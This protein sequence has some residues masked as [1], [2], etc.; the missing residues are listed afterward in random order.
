MKKS[1]ILLTIIGISFT[2]RFL[3]SNWDSNTKLNPDERFITMV[4]TS[5]KVPS[6]L[7]TYFD[8]H[9][10][11]FNPHNVGHTYYVY[12]TLPVFV[13]KLLALQFNVDTYEK[14]TLFGRHLS[15]VLDTISTLLVFGIAYNLTKRFRTSAIATLVYALAV[16]PIQLSHFY[17]VD[18]WLVLFSTTTLYVLTSKPR[19]RNFAF[20]GLT[21]G[22]AVASKIQAFVLVPLVGVGFLYWLPKMNFKR[23]LLGGVVC[24]IL[25]FVTVRVSQPYLFASGKFLEFRPNPKVLANW[26]ELQR[27]YS[28]ATYANSTD[29]VYFPPASMF[30]KAAPITFLANNLFFWGLGIPASIYLVLGIMATSIAS[31]KNRKLTLLSVIVIW[32][33]GVFLYQSLLFAKYLRYLAVVYPVFAVVAAIGIQWLSTKLNPRVTLLVSCALL[34]PWPMAF[35]SIYLKPHPRVAASEWI[36]THLSANDKVTFEHWDDPL[37]L[38]LPQYPCPLVTQLELP[39]YESDSP[40]KWAKVAAVLNQAD[41]IILSSNRLYGS[42]TWLPERYPITN[43]YYQLLFSGQ[44]GFRLERQF[45]NRPTLPFPVSTCIHLPDVGYGTI[46]KPYENCTT[47][48]LQIVD[49]YTDESFTVYDHPAVFIFK[50]VSPINYFE[51][52]GLQ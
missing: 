43:K 10:S 11:T 3:G 23:W 49:D 24:I 7:S 51:V 8:P 12:G 15:A 45:T 14:V 37:P 32:S 4:T 5:L 6:S 34:V 40:A 28:Q 25:C 42:I 41:Y 29:G 35:S 36:Y 17:T 39:L 21:L 48:G 47:G 52:L 38:C 9:T 16:L 2:L 27:L 46:A 22:L 33:C 1:L 26:Q 31:F 50:K 13:V 19:I 30:I 20:C 18:P 44:L